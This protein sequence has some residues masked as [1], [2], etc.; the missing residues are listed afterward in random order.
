MKE[1]SREDLGP[2]AATIPLLSLAELENYLAA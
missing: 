2:H 1:L